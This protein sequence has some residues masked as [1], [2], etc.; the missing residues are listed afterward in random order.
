MSLYSKNLGKLLLLWSCC[1]LAAAQAQAAV[2]TKSRQVSGFVIVAESAGAQLFLTDSLANLVDAAE[3][4]LHVEVTDWST[5]HV[6]TDLHSQHNLTV[7][8][9]KLANRVMELRSKHP[10][11]SIFLVGNG[12][13]TAVVVRAADMLPP[14]AVERVI[15][16]GPTLTNSYDLRRSLQAS[17][18]GIDTFYC[19]QDLTLELTGQSLG[20]N[21]HGKQV[22]TCA[23]LTGFVPRVHS[24]A[25]AS[26]YG[27]LRQNAVKDTSSGD[28][29]DLCHLR[30]MSTSFLSAR[31]MPIL[32]STMRARADLRKATV[33]PLPATQA[34][35]PALQ[36]QLPPPGV[37]SPFD[38][39]MPIVADFPSPQATRR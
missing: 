12:S 35:P 20:T 29:V 31:I 16:L 9:R 34:A 26:L 38:R 24:A 30:Y 23:G 37:S 21:L 4:P 10:G 25:D 7:K 11:A 5:L 17:S 27:K 32:T 6:P 1:S 8:S 13:G 18:A 22:S 33:A 3:L 28:Q 15:L 19:K 2:P 39:Q 36:L 14:H